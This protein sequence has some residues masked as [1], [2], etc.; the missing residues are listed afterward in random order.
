M[1]SY[2]GAEVCDLIGLFP[3]KDLSKINKSK[4]FGLYCDD[5]LL[6]I[7]KSKCEHVKKKDSF[8]KTIVLV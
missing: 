3:R 5:V 8:S 7:K 2:I 4:H 6:V 1:G